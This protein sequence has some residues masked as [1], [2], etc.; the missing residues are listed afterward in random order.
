VMVAALGADPGFIALIVRTGLTVAAGGL[1]IVA[2]S[3]ALRIGELGTIVGL[4]FD[5]IRRRGRA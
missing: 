2:G 3:R 1:V 4:M 5:L